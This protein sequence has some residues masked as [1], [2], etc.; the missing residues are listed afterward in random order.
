MA[1]ALRS[2]MDIGAR[3]GGREAVP[4][5]DYHGSSRTP[6]RLWGRLGWGFLLEF[7]LK[8]CYRYPPYRRFAIPVCGGAPEGGTMGQRGPAYRVVS[9]GAVGQSAPDL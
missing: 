8:E 5:A 9:A 1:A 4:L 3:R 2:A 7:L 6:P